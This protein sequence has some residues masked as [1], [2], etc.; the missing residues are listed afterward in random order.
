[1]ETAGNRLLGIHDSL[2][3]TSSQQDLQITGVYSHVDPEDLKSDI[4]SVDSKPPPV[5]KKHEMMYMNLEKQ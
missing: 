1:M 3:V 2:S 4:V 5:K